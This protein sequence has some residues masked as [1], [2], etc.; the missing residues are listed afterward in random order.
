MFLDLFEPEDTVVCDF[1]L[2]VVRTNRKKTASIQIVDGVVRVVV[3]KRLSQRELQRLIQ[4]K[5]PWI[6]NKLRQFAE[7]EPV[8]LKRY[9]SGEQFPYLGRRYR[10]SLIQGEEGDQVKLIAGAL[11]LGVGG[12]EEGEAQQQFVKQRLEQWYRYQ[13]EQQLRRRTEHYAAQLG[14]EPRV[15]RVRGY[16]SRWGSCFSNGE[17]RYNWR[18]ILAPQAIVDY[19]VVHELCHLLEMNHSPRFWHCVEQI[20]P[21]YRGCRAWLKQHGTELVL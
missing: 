10:L 7:L 11:Q 5:S 2:Q 1:P 21:D 3:P 8:K 6:Q 20:L 14:V 4:K 19:L 16:K 9:V 17:I 13:A 12:V 18:I 15:V